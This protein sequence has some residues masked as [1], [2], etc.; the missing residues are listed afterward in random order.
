M[1]NINKNLASS[2][3][4]KRKIRVY[5]ANI[6]TIF[7]YLIQF[8]I[9]LFIFFKNHKI[10]SPLKNFF[11]TS[12]TTLGLKIQEVEING[13]QNF[14]VKNTLLKLKLNNMQSIFSIDLSKIKELLESDKWVRKAE[15]HRVFPNKLI[16]NLEE[17][18]PIAVWQY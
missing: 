4:Q 14:D 17:R 12:S 3:L 11:I 2:S 1:I 15:I 10:I 8:S 7:K 5:F 9:L 18:R 13:C 6:K 16:I